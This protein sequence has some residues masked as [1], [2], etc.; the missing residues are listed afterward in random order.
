MAEEF[1]PQAMIER[2]RERARAVRSRGVPPVE[3]PER[4][5]FI[6]QAQIDYMDFAML[7]DADASLDDGVL[8]IRVDLRPKP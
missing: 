3:G 4:K 8:T 5:R 7:S 1:D 2:F 6:E